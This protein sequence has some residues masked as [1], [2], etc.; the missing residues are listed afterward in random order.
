MQREIFNTLC[1]NAGFGNGLLKRK[2]FPIFTIF[3]TSFALSTK[4]NDYLMSVWIIKSF[5]AFECIKDLVM[6]LIQKTEIAKLCMKGNFASPRIW[7]FLIIQNNWTTARIINRNFFSLSSSFIFFWFNE[8]KCA[9]SYQYA[10]T[11]L[12]KTMKWNKNK[13]FF[14]FVLPLLNPD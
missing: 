8:H 3:F 11:F 4:M 2:T 13:S 6:L 7:K 9:A 5:V 14:V 1:G 12:H 10:N